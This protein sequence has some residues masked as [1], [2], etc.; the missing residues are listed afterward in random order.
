MMI[1]GEFNNPADW[2]RAGDA[3]ATLIAFSPAMA[4][5]RLGLADAV[6]RHVLVCS[7]RVN[8]WAAGVNLRPSSP[9]KVGRRSV[10]ATSN[11]L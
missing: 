4:N 1:G 7:G 9:G 3:E 8:R 2:V 11:A 10:G 6:G 5:S